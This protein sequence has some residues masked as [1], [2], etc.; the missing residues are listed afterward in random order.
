M[1]RLKDIHDYLIS[2]GKKEEE[3]LKC[4]NYSVFLSMEICEYAHRNQK[5][6]N[7]EDY[8]NHPFRCLGMYR[9]FVGIIENDPFCIDKDIMLKHGIPF[10]GVQELCLL[11]DVIEDTDFTVK[12][13]EEI[14]DECGLKTYFSL[15]IETPLKLITHKKSDDYDEYISQVLKHPTS[16]LVKM[17]DLYD[18]LNPTSLNQL[19]EKEE[20]RMI[21][22]LSYVIVIN[23]AYDFVNNMNK[24]K[25]EFE[26]DKKD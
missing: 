12:D 14:F 22:Y 15:Y 13:L 8:A 5:R 20:K 17:L 26:N 3:L 7:G 23:R 21:D 9:E 25:K 2:V 6:E 16:S 4:D 24:Y 19:N 18:N 1:S 10:D 11:H